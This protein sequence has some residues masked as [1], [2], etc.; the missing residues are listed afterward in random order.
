MSKE[1]LFIR[2]WKNK[3]SILEGIKNNVFKQD[4]VEQIYNYRF[5]ICKSCDSMDTTGEH[6]A[7]PKT[8]PCCAECGCSFSIK[9]RSLSAECDLKKWRA[10]LSEQEEDALTNHLDEKQGGFT[11]QSL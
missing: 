3:G 10:E 7:I 2:A 4:H 5:D 8:Q 11:E 1:S 9:L 6:C